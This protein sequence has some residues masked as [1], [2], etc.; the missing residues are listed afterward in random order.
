MEGK[1]KTVKWM[2]IIVWVALA[3]TEDQ[4]QQ[5]LMQVHLLAHSHID[6]GWRKTFSEYFYKDNYEVDKGHRDFIGGARA[7]YRSMVQ[8]LLIDRQ[9][10]YVVSEM[11]YFE[12]WY[13]HCSDHMKKIVRQLINEKRIEIGGGGYVAADDATPYYEDLIDMTM[14][15]HEWLRKTFGIR[16]TT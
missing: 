15:G 4:K 1:V 7:I 10:K 5:D 6:P 11:C 9:K 8:E 13:K 2:L 14:I 3:T 12:L 16:P